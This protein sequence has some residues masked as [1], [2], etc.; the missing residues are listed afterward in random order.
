MISAIIT[1]YF[2]G[3]FTVMGLIVIDVILVMLRKG[4]LDEYAP[5]R[6]ML[7]GLIF[8]TVLSWIGVIAIMFINIYNIVNYFIGRPRIK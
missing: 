4:N 2:Y 8:I 5:K 1:W 3:M 6:E 7:I